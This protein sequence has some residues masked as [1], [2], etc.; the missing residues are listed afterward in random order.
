MKSMWRKLER[1][2]FE[3]WKKFYAREEAMDVDYDM[4]E[5]LWPQK[6]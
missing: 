2:N 1:S 5:K 4:S 3:E 6:R